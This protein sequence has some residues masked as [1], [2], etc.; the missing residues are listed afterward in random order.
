MVMLLGGNDPAW[1]RY[2]DGWLAMQA[3][4]RLFAKLHDHW[5]TVTH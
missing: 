1:L 3:N 5:I 2:M 4:Q